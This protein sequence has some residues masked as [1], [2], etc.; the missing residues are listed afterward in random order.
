MDMVMQ[1][2]LAVC[3]GLIFAIMVT[4]I[5]ILFDDVKKLERM[6]ESVDKDS[7]SREARMI[8]MYSGTTDAITKIEDQLKY[9]EDR[10]DAGKSYSSCQDW[11]E[12]K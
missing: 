2:A 1:I 6:I 3:G 10:W 5:V 8:A 12:H 4:C 7:Y 11:D 9:K